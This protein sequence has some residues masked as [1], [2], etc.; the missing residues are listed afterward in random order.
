MSET[1][2]ITIE[3]KDDLSRWEAARVLLNE[4]RITL[5]EYHQVVNDIR[6]RRGLKDID[7]TKESK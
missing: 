4:K 2:D 3:I 1:G 7:F 5:D 6:R